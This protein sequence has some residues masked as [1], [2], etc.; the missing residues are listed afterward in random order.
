MV[1]KYSKI[2]A[3]HYKGTPCNFE[4]SGNEAYLM[5]K[6]DGSVQGNGFKLRYLTLDQHG[7]NNAPSSKD[8]IL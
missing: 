7:N 6:T 2:H 1:L 8:K 5:M 3:F 4:T